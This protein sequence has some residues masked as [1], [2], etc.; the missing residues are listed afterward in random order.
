M[1]WAGVER[2][3][4][5]GV[6]LNSASCRMDLQMAFMMAPVCTIPSF[7][8]ELDKQDMSNDTA[9]TFFHSFTHSLNKYG[10]YYVPDTFLGGRYSYMLDRHKPCPEEH[11]PSASQL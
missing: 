3:Q 4:S 1:I 10:T 2:E 9:A 8:P 5:R 7:T 6:Q 11:S